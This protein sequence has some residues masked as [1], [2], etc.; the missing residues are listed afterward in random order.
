MF[1]S[2][3]MQSWHTKILT[4]ETQ[5]TWI[6]TEIVHIPAPPPLQVGKKVSRGQPHQLNHFLH[7]TCSPHVHASGRASLFYISQ[8][9]I[10]IYTK[11][12][13]NYYFFKSR[14]MSIL[15]YQISQNT[16]Q[17]QFQNTIQ[18]FQPSQVSSMRYGVSSSV[19]ALSVPCA[20]YADSKQVRH[21]NK[22]TRQANSCH[23][24]EAE[25]TS[26]GCH[27]LP[28]HPELHTNCPRMTYK[29]TQPLYTINAF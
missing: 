3:T 25:S 1:L 14:P 16:K 10:Q 17:V 13:F 11:D 29:F 4:N 22:G 20:F 26:S 19:P 15:K 24:C 21:C 18:I 8:L 28:S 2:F 27:T 7:L 6:I 9:K 23:L 5:F 12:T